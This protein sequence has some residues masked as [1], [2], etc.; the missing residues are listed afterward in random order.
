MVNQEVR[1]VQQLKAFDSAIDILWK[2]QQ[3]RPEYEPRM[4][5][6]ELQGQRSPVRPRRRQEDN[7]KTNLTEAGQERVDRI[8]LIYDRDKWQTLVTTVTNLWVP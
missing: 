8:N 2:F 4:G 6:N 1:A 3:R 7:I 5:E